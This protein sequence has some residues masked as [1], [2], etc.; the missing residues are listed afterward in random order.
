MPS[1]LCLCFGLWYTYLRRFFTATP[2]IFSILW[3]LDGYESVRSLVD[4][5]RV[6]IPRKT[7]QN[8][9]TLKIKT[10]LK[11]VL[12]ER[13]SHLQFKKT[14]FKVHGYS[15]GFEKINNVYEFS[16]LNPFDILVEHSSISRILDIQQRLCYL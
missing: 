1:I 7:F 16:W 15:P 6:V 4:E 14:Y 9:R 8:R 11:K 5:N 10:Y 2:T 13:I 12:N 3:G